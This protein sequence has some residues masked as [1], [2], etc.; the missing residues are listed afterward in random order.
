MCIISNLIC[1]FPNFNTS[2]VCVNFLNKSIVVSS[3]HFINLST[4]LE[5]LESWHACDLTIFSS[6]SIDININCGAHNCITKFLSKSMILWFNHLA[7]WAPCCSEI[8]NKKF[9]RVTIDKSIKFSFSFD[10]LNHFVM[11]LFRF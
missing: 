7:W 10:F 6:L 8:N 3:L 11:Y 4:I 5:E 9:T 1:L 2:L